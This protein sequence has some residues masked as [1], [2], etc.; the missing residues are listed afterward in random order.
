[1]SSVQPVSN[2]FLLCL[3]AY[4]L[5]FF[6]FIQHCLFW[7]YF[8]L[9][10]PLFCYCFY[11]ICM[12]FY[13]HFSICLLYRQS[14]VFNFV[15]VFFLLTW[16]F[17]LHIWNCQA[18]LIKCLFLKLHFYVVLIM[19]LSVLSFMMPEPKRFIFV[20]IYKNMFQSSRYL[21]LCSLQSLIW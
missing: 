10:S 2:F 13:L 7:F 18:K 12:I 1:M 14:S 20:F 6:V 15:E 8:L 9:F 3:P 17:L 21:Y 16:Q 4:G 5:Y 11:D 19:S